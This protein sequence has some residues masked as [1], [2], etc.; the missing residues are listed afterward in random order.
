MT[1]DSP[2]ATAPAPVLSIVIPVFQEG[3]HLAEVITRVRV[4]AAA[5][6]EPY[7]IILVDDGS[8]DETWNVIAEQGARFA[9]LRALR[10]SRNFG[11]E[12]ALCAGLDAARG[13][14]VVVMDG[15]LQHPPELLP[16]MVALWQD[17]RVDLVEAVKES[18]GKESM[19]NRVG[20]R[21]FYLVLNKLAG[22][23]LNNASD[24]KL[25][26]RRVVDAWRA[27]GERNL[28]FR[29]MVAWLGFQRAEVR[30]S[31]AGRAGGHSGWSLLTLTKLAVTA[32]T[33][34]SS[35]PLQIVTLLGA[36]FFL[37]ATAIGARTLYLYF[38]GEAVSGF[39]TV[40]LLVLLIGGMQMLC[41]GIFGAYIGRIYE[42]VKG[43]PRYLIKERVK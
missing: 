8:R 5:A 38:R 28:Y 15:D 17:G 40:I 42:E 41:L 13:R 35:S 29:G 18:R 37:F 9:D 25:M 4:H 36:T 43:R 23:D 20:A 11:K 16:Q 21:L 24:F 22:Q 6:G 30:F 39:T 31:V 3:A 32:L 1:D 34:F 14:A 19:A 10:L 12:A 33:A 2:L 26:D 7:E 27:M